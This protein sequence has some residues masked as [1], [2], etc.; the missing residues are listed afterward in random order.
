LPVP[1]RL[2]TRPF[3]IVTASTMAYFLALGIVQPVLPRYV[4]HD[5]GLGGLAVGVAVGAF[6]LTAA[7]L[8]PLAG[9]IGDRYGR[10]VLILGGA[11]IAGLSLLGYGLGR[12]F[13]V[14]LLMRLIT[15]VGEAAVFVGAATIA[16]DLS[17]PSRRGE[18]ASYFSV[19]I[20]GGLGLGAPLGDFIRHAVGTAAVWPAAAVACGV[21]CILACF[22]PPDTGMVPAA[23]ADPHRKRTFLQRDAIRPGV[24][25]LMAMMGYAGFSTFV[26]VYVDRVGLDNAGTVLG[27]YALIVLGI[28]IVGA[29][30]P[31]RLGPVRTSTLALIV[32]GTGLLLMAA[33]GT[34]VGLYVSTVVF[35]C[36][37]SLLYP[38]LFP[39]VVDGAPEAERS[40][41]V[42]TFTL[43]FDISQAVGALALGAV[44]AVADERA[45]FAVA[46]V[47]CLVAIAL[48]RVSVGERPPLAVRG[49]TVTNH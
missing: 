8:R 11:A 35:S 26:P 28:R 17:P 21:T 24:I 16:Q 12:S 38:A 18:A 7:A 37:Q 49:A 39:L 1:D 22:V 30:I 23:A 25:L 44:V 46:G 34:A 43:F 19:A 47:V 15:G 13:A 40:Q 20:Y 4:K 10:R 42:A 6:A 31:D 29:R 36:G 45:A 33:W 41:A 14:L 3:L 32:L 9:H 48:L 2:L 5:L 27:L